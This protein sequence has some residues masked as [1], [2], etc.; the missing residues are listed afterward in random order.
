MRELAIADRGSRNTDV[1]RECV[2]QSPRGAIRLKPFHPAIFPRII[3]QR[4]RNS[5]AHAQRTTVITLRGDA[6]R[7]LRRA[8]VGSWRG[9]E[10]AQWRSARVAETPPRCARELSPLAPAITSP[11]RLLAD[12]GVQAQQAP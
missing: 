12:R 5:M 4:E 10:A 8:R 3:C 2:P 6:A 9:F 11:P 1:A 7:D